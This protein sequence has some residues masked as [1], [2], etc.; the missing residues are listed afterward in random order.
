[1][2]GF[3]KKIL[4][5][6]DEDLDP[7]K[8]ID[9]IP[10]DNFSNKDSEIPLDEKFADNFTNT[11]G[12][13][14]YCANQQEVIHAINDIISENNWDEILS[15]D[16]DI[17]SLLQRTG[18]TYSNKTDTNSAFFTKCEALIAHDGS[19][20]I[21]SNQLKGR[22]L[23]NL[24]YDFIILS[25]INFIIENRSDAL[26]SLISRYGKDIPSGI[27]T[28]KGPKTVTGTN[29]ILDSGSINTSKNIYLLL[30]E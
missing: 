1:M 15:F 16:E 11:G 29:N 13:F 17:N 2:K 30:V 24:P 25:K 5:I 8:E 3:F 6:K 27:T 4:G 19:I 23:P 12:K 20:L 18:V 26:G 21:S 9:S 10:I 7:K 22:K 28:V 14:I